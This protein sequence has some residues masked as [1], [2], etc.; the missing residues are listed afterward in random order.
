MTPQGRAFGLAFTGTKKT[1]PGKSAPLFFANY[2]N[3][4]FCTVAIPGCEPS[5]TDSSVAIGGCGTS[6]V[7][8]NRFRPV[9][10]ISSDSLPQLKSRSIALMFGVNPGRTCGYTGC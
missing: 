6:A 10:K 7:W 5:L 1:E 8:G 2:L 3:Y 9:L 4:C